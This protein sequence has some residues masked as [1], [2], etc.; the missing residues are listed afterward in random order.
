MRDAKVVA[1]L[2]GAIFLTASTSPTIADGDVAL[3]PPQ[4]YP[5][6]YEHLNRWC[7]PDALIINGAGGQALLR[8]EQTEREMTRF[9]DP[10]DPAV[11]ESGAQAAESA[12][13]KLVGEFDLVYWQTNGDLAVHRLGKDPNARWQAAPFRRVEYVRLPE[14]FQSWARNGDDLFASY[15][16]SCSDDDDPMADDCVGVQRINLATLDRDQIFERRGSSADRHDGA[17]TNVIM[18]RDPAHI[19]A[20]VDDKNG[21]SFCRIDPASLAQDC[22]VALTI[23]IERQHDGEYRRLSI[24]DDDTAGGFYEIDRNLL[25][26]QAWDAATTRQ[27]MCRMVTLRAD[28]EAD[29]ELRLRAVLQDG[30]VLVQANRCLSLG[31]IDAETG[32]VRNLQCLLEPI[33]TAAPDD[34]ASALVDEEE[35]TGEEDGVTIPAWDVSVS[36]TGKWIAIQVP[37]KGCG[38]RVPKPETFEP[39]VS[40]GGCGQMMVWRADQ[41][42]KR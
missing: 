13:C 4:V 35:F 11:I 39:A 37:L 31:E 17:T 42:L 19:V 30:L 1:A 6:A 41:F 3:Y 7:G 25:H 2:V 40:I 23:R 8:L 9:N 36:P 38:D 18:M 32:I 24:D 10:I 20:V 29:G 5:I 21:T 26:C 15:I 22:R 33:K 28:G 34:V 27:P 12:G 14:G 16:R